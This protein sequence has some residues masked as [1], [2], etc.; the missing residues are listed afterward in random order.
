M[1]SLARRVAPLGIGLLLLLGL[2]PVASATSLPAEADVAAAESA[3]LTRINDLRVGHGL[4]RLRV[5]PRI[6]ELARE[7]AEYMASTDVLSHEHAGGKM[8]WDLMS[9]DGITWYG[10]GEIIAYNSTRPLSS[11][12]ATAVKGWLGS[13]PHR[14][15]M[16]SSNYNY[17]GMGLAVSPSTGRRYWAGVFLKGPDRTGA[18]SKL[19]K[20]TKASAGTAS[21]K[22]SFRWSGS[23]TKLQVLTSGLRYYQ[24]QRRVDGGEWL[25]YGTT[26]N[27]STTRNFLRG[28]TIDFRVRARDKSGNWGAWRVITVKS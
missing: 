1:R 10:A 20:L 4:V 21:V 16:L 18:W 23:D 2:A 11:S 22:V 24:T 8:V 6:S 9:E 7:R 28:H 19:G 25:D 3:A 13:P 14:S 12:A 15:I 5:D 17:F 27:T 26:T